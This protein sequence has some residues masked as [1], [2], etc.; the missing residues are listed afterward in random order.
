MPYYSLLDNTDITIVV[1][2]YQ[3]LVKCLV[4]EVEARGG[5][6]SMEEEEE[7]VAQL[8]LLRDVLD[9]AQGLEL[10]QD[11]VL[12]QDQDREAVV[13]HGNASQK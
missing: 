1:E 10:I 12:D 4:I 13:S 2:L 5:I 8:L 7:M 3:F 11:P 6:P 9:H